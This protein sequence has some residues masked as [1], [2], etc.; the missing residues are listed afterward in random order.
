MPVL[1]TSLQ[2]GRVVVLDHHKTAFEQFGRPAAGCADIQLANCS[3]HLDMDKSGATLALHHFQPAGLTDAQRQL[4]SFIEDA[5]LWR[6]RLPHSREFHA[7]LNLP[8]Y[9][10]NED[11]LVPFQKRTA[12]TSQQFEP[13]ML[14]I[15]QSICRS[16]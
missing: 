11:A 12:A 4:F 14:N 3:V 7:G 8:W 5:D 6:W 9:I 15:I 2:V 1:T 10:V 16:R 13:A